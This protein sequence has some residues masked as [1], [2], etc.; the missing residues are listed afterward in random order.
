M[1]PLP[2]GILASSLSLAGAYDL[3][4]TQTLATTAASV[5]F[6]G[7]D[8]LAAGY[9]HLQL[10]MTTRST[11]SGFSTN[12]LNVN[13]DTG[14]NYSTHLL[15]G[16]GSSVISFAYTSEAYIRFGQTA[17]SSSPT[18]AFTATVMDILDFSSASKNTTI[19]ALSGMENA[20]ST[21]VDLRSGLWNSTAAVTSLAIKNFDTYVAGS[22]F[23]LYGVK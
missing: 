16:L 11:N 10:R 17:T 20:A 7:L 3:L 6:T 15:S 4:E 18:S 23:S 2:L 8:T 12:Y 9:Q 22:R 21:R 13:S 1:T 19:R 14:T 5:T